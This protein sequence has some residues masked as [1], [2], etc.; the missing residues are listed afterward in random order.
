M[1][2]EARAFIERVTRAAARGPR[3]TGAAPPAIAD[4]V[5]RQVNRSADLVETFMVNAVEVGMAAQFVP[6][7]E[8]AAWVAG[9]V[10][11]GEG[12]V[13]VDAALGDAAAM[14]GAIG[15]R[16]RVVGG[17]MDDETLFGAEAG[18]VV[19]QA[20]VAETGSLVFTSVAGRMRGLTLAPPRLVVVLDA[21]EIVAD[22]VDL[23]GRLSGARGIRASQ[24]VDGG[25][26]PPG[27]PQPTRLGEPGARGG[28]GGTGDSEL[29][30]I[31]NVSIVT[32]PSKTADIEGIP[33]TG[34]H[35]PGE[36]RIG[37]IQA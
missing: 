16:A 2:R 35:G 26:R 28:D 11:V 32:G 4:A 13:L 33:I 18:V 19:A 21:K 10:G 15:A 7:G 31:G 3:V 34:V 23:F 29:A 22:L 30:L 20:G 24:R 1:N 37:V 27:R 12:P 6:P 36:V 5:V 9:A 25:F 17:A 8:M 14:V